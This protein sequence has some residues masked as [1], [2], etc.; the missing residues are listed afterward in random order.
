MK[1]AFA[2]TAHKIQGA[3]ISKPEKSIVNITD[4]FKPAMV[5]VMLSRIYSIDQLIILNEFDETK[6]YPSKIA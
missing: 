4:T 2:S 1:L 5:Y 6:M 3:T